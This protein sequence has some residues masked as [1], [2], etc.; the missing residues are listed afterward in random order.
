MTDHAALM[1]HL[2]DWAKRCKSPVIGTLEFRERID[3]KTASRVFDE[4]IR[5]VEEGIRHQ[6]TCFRD[7]EQDAEAGSPCIYVLI[8]GLEPYNVAGVRVL[9]EKMAG[10][11]HLQFIEPESTSAPSSSTHVEDGNESSFG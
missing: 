11:A 1:K 9:W 6:L 2:L 5:R 10:E 4:W 7:L 3:P 8:D